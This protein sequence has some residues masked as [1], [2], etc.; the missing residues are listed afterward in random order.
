[1]KGWKTLIFAII[2]AVAGA[3]DAFDWVQ[4]V[5]EGWNG[6]VLGGVGILTAYLRSITTTPMLKK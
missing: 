4:V 3:L 6:I 1:M 5:P 2:V